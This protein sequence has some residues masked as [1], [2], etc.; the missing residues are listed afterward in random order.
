MKGRGSAGRRFFLWLKRYADVESPLVGS[1]CSADINQTS[2]FSAPLMG[3]V[4]P[5]TSAGFRFP[6]SHASRKKQ[7]CL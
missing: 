1:R 6:R 4:A 3:P 7:S 5:V 2:T